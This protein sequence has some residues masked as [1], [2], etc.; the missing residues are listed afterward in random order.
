[1]TFPA[2][3]SASEEILRAAALRNGINAAMHRLKPDDLE[4]VL[5]FVSELYK[6]YTSFPPIIDDSSGIPF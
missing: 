2:Y 1:M 3:P 6:P 4:Q 5:A